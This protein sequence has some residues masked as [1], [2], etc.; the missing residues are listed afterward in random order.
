LPSVPQ[1]YLYVDQDKVLKQGIDLS[2]VYKTSQV[3]PCSRC[4]ALNCGNTA[5]AFTAAPASNAFTRP[6]LFSS[7]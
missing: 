7:L 1:L 5:S 4:S 6:G 2:D 3:I